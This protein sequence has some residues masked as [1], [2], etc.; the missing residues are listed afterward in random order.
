VD[1]VFVLAG[2]VI[3]GVMVGAAAALPVALYGLWS[4]SHGWYALPNSVLLKSALF[5]RSVT[6][7]LERLT[8][9]PHMLP[10]LV[11]ACAL[12]VLDAR[13]MRSWRAFCQNRWRLATLLFFT[14]AM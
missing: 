10:L 8:E 7:M 9:N 4:M 11:A 5:G 3:E 12:L 13:D 14:V 6:T 2:C 1:V